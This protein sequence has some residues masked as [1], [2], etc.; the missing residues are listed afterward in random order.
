MSRPSAK[1][2]WSPRPGA[3]SFNRVSKRRAPQ[4]QCAVRVCCGVCRRP[5]R[6]RNST[7]R[8]ILC[9]WSRDLGRL[10]CA[11]RQHPEEL[12][13]PE[14][15]HSAINCNSSEDRPVRKRRVRH[16]EGRL[17]AQA[18]KAVT[19]ASLTVDLLN[20]AQQKELWDLC[21][22]ITELAVPRKGRCD[23]TLGPAARDQAPAVI[24]V[25]R[26]CHH[27]ATQSGLKLKKFKNRERA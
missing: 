11:R 19:R 25:F 22:I 23:H 18:A 8:I 12:R 14:P 1:S 15:R 7:S 5:L 27:R 26:K 10:F 24:E 17:F 4:F 21:R 16:R 13:I 6:P 20:V 3:A 2:S 9:S